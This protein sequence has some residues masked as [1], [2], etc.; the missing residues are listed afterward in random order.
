MSFS[1]PGRTDRTDFC[2]CKSIWLQCGPDHVELSEHFFKRKDA[3]ENDPAAKVR[4][5][6]MSLK[7]AQ[8]GIATDWTQYLADAEGCEGAACE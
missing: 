6:T 3:V 4:N 5:G 1:R 8:V 2:A 7:E